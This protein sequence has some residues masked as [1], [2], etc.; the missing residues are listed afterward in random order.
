MNIRQATSEDLIKVQDCNL[1]CLPENYQIKYY[2]YH[3]L[4]WPH[5]SY[6]AEDTKGNIIGY[7]LAKMEE[8]MEDDEPH[9]HITSL[10]VKRTFRR[11]GLAQKLMNQT[12][13]SMVEV[14]NA[15]YVSLH[16]RKS[17]RAAL[18]LYAHT[19]K[20]DIC[21]MEPKYYADGEDAYMMKRRLVQYAL[22]NNIEPADRST[23]FQPPNER[24]GKG[25][26]GGGGAGAGAETKK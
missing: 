23:F 13:R 17:N 16:V 22:D 25:R 3:F 20:F 18:N 21:D 8:E 15:R 19:L 1:L 2:M 14:Y 26:G 7:V 12:A 24:K 4:S 9:G 6:I 5:L 11:L 10:A